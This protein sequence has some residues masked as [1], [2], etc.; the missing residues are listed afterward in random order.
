M[1]HE[2]IITRTTTYSC[3]LAASR[4]ESLRIN[5]DKEKVVRVYEDGKIGIS[6]CVGDE[7]D[8]SL[9]GRAEKALA[10]GIPYPC[11]LTEDTVRHEDAREPIIKPEGFLETI[12]HLADRLA[13]QFPGF[14]FSNKLT[15]GEETTE[16]SNSRKTDLCYS[17]SYF[18]LYIVIKAKSSAN[19][20]DLYY[21]TVQSCY[22]E[23]A[24]V[25]DIGKL[26]N[27]YANKLPLPE[28]ELPVIISEGDVA[29]YALR[30]MGAE[31]YMSGTSLLKGKLGEKVFDEKFSL[32][33]DRAP[34]N[35]SCYPFFDTEGTVKEGD[36]FYFVKEGV[37]QGLSTCKRTAAKF[38]LPLSGTASS[39][40]DSVP[41]AGF[42]GVSVAP[43]QA[44]LSDI[45]KGKAVYAYVTSGGDM[46]PDGTLGIPVMLAYL[47][48]DG[49]LVGTLPEFSLS[50]SIFDVLGKDYLGTAENDI[51]SFAG[52]D[53]VIVSKF[54]LNRGA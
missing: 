8:E 33:T 29:L 5:E 30:E 28:E 20:M 1:E 14:I 16:Y 27:V 10:Q 32:V 46:T 36:K 25:S 11:A 38:S 48:E 45:V 2:R 41:S 9:L 7:A 44:K 39:G 54:T 52:K 51:F 21:G 3:N 26:L 13:K 50:G 35:R 4:V 42:G 34:H 24:I 43:T 18:T 19:I 49:K 12:S 40:F 15:L 53:K 17:G 23:D 22:D 6:A 37:F 31:S 47:Y